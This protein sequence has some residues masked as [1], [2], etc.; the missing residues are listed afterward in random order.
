M[1]L[2]IVFDLSLFSVSANRYMHVKMYHTHYSQSAHVYTLA[3]HD[4][5]QLL[6][7]QYGSQF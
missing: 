3:S 5:T 7:T 2:I 1:R 4:L 6:I